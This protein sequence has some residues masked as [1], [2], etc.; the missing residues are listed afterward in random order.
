MK[1]KFFE[2]ASAVIMLMITA[3]IIALG[4]FAIIY[5]NELI[6][7]YGA[8]GFIAIGAAGT[9]W[10]IWTLLPPKPKMGKVVKKYKYNVRMKDYRTLRSFDVAKKGVQVYRRGRIRMYSCD[11]WVFYQLSEGVVYDLL[12]KNGTIIGVKNMT[13]YEEEDGFDENIDTEP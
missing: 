2:I 1:N 6:G 3:G 5:D 7:I 9:F 10:V 12:I 8:V 11:D 4:V 13:S